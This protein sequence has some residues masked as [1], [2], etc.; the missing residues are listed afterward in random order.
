MYLKKKLSE[1]IYINTLANLALLYAW[2]M[3]KSLRWKTTNYNKKDSGVIYAIWH[4]SQYG[5]GVFKEEERKKLNILISPSNDGDII[6]KIIHK[7]GFSAIRGSQKRRGAQAV[8][9]ICNIL[10][11]GQ[12]VAY[13]VDG[14]RGPIYE[15]KK[16]IIKIAQLSQKPIIP[17]V[18][19]TTTKFEANSWDKYQVPF[20]S[21]RLVAV[22]GDPINVP[23]DLSEDQEEF[24]R[25]KL[26]NT[27]LN[28]QEIANN[29][30]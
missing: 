2:P 5:L 21:S 22:F 1:E 3:D 17:L 23:K 10:E 7:L 8:R 29:S 28:M 30:L 19:H 15:V 9:D 20:M 12:N 27:L 4:G 24:Y 14:P 13:T 6:A 11:Q 16:G 25:K 26:E 18:S